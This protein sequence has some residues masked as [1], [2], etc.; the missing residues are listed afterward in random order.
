M[1]WIVTLC[2]FI[3]LRNGNNESLFHAHRVLRGPKGSGASMVIRVDGPFDQSAPGPVL[4]NL[5]FTSELRTDLMLTPIE[6]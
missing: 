4:V 1:D 6:F 2:I 3:Y 5:G